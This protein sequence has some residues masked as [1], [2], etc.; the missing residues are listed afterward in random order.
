MRRAQ[1]RVRGWARAGRTQIRSFDPD[2]VF[3]YF[4]IW[5]VSP[6]LLPE[7]GDWLQ[8]GDPQLDTWQLS[9]YQA[10]A[11]VLSARRAGRV[12]HDPL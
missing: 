4:S 1:R 10:A 6:R 2:V 12:V 7:S 8:P 9:E 3:V 5:E 11:D